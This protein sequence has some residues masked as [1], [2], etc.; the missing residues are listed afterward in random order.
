VQLPNTL[1]EPRNLTGQQHYVRSNALLLD[2]GAARL[3]AAP[4]IFAVGPTISPTF[5]AAD[6]TNQ[7]VAT[8]DP[9]HNFNTTPARLFISIS[10][11]QNPGVKFYK[12][13]FRKIGGVNVPNEAAFPIGPFPSPF[14]FNLNQVV[15]IRTACVLADGRVGVPTIQRIFPS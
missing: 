1:G 13:P 4:T 11:P 6:A 8:T 15:F 10:K 9:N 7:V 3:D 5:V 2:T 12:S 14:D